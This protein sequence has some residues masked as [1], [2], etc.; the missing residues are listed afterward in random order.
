MGTPQAQG[1]TTAVADRGEGRRRRRSVA[2]AR[3]AG[4]LGSVL[5]SVLVALALWI[6]FIRIYHVQPII[7]KSPI[8]VWRYLFTQKL[9]T[10]HALRS[11]AENRHVLFTHLKTTL[12]DASLGYLA[13][14]VLA[15]GVS[16]LFVMRRTLEQ[17]F[18]PTALV[19]RSV[20]LIA[21]APLLTLLFGRDV[22]VVAVIGGI[23]C[24]FPALVNIM[25]GLRSSPRSSLDLMRSYGASKF[26][27]L[28]KVMVPSAL[29][30]IFASL[31]INVP[32]SIVGALLAEWLATGKGSG[33]EMLT[34]V[35]TFDYGELWSA[36]VLVTLV[37]MVLYSIVSAVEAAVLA[38][39]APDSVGR[40]R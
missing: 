15:L 21:M 18:M 5:V 25:L 39:Y 38:R 4:N 11:A 16:C 13:G 9:D 40:A 14:I 26:T 24:F 36:V 27:T 7:A 19:L 8:D 30:S 12:R 2:A 31:R 3:L 22:L 34:V 10:V 33:A 6:G 32:A 29:P 23:V 28:R 17:T 20:P 35:N 37:A 1:V